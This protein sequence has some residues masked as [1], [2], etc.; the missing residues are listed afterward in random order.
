LQR[1]IFPTL[2]QGDNS[3]FVGLGEGLVGNSSGRNA[4]FGEYGLVATST[5]VNEPS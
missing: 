5:F 2:G 4:R 1:A 3:A